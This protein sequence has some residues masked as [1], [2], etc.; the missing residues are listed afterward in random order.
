MIWRMIVS[1]ERRPGP[2]VGPLSATA[3]PGSRLGSLG[4]AGVILAGLVLA[5]LWAAWHL[6]LD[7]RQLSPGRGGWQLAT[8]FFSAAL[9]P[10]WRFEGLYQGTGLAPVPMQALR[11]AGTTIIFCGDFSFAGAGRWSGPRISRLLQSHARAGI[12]PVGGAGSH[13][14][15]FAALGA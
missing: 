3:R 1:F 13:F 6:Q 9:H 15:Q 5:G 11:A 12:A 10:A 2:G 8:D 4:T 14:E 7:V